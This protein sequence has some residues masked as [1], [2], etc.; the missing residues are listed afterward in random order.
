MVSFQVV[1]TDL[2]VPSEFQYPTILRS[3][4]GAVHHNASHYLL[5]G[6]KVVSGILRDDK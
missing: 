5:Y 1:Q 6:E 2:S 4:R 3:A